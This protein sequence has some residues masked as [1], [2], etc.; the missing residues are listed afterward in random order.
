MSKLHPIP[1]IPGHKGKIYRLGR[2][3]NP[4]A[5]PWRFECQCGLSKVAQ[6]QAF[7]ARLKKRHENEVVF[8]NEAVP[9]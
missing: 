1:P 2:S 3:H 8:G 5:G 9:A 6:G 7:V 4:E